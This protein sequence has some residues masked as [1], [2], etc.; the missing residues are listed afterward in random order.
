[1]SGKGSRSGGLMLLRILAS[2]AIVILHTLNVSEILYRDRIS[3]AADAVSMGIVYCLMW[4]VPVFVMVSGALLLDPAREMSIKK[5]LTRYVPRVLGAL[6][7]FV[8]IFRIFDCVM[9]KEEFSGAVLTDALYKL[10]SGSS[11]SHL[12]YLYMLIGLYLLLPAYRF[13]SEKCDEKTFL[14]LTVVCFI[15]LSIL[16]LTELFGFTSAFH[17]QLSAVYT[18]YFFL[19]YGLYSGKLKLNGGWA[20]CFIIA[21]TA[22]TIAGTYF[23]RGDNADAVK[24]IVSAYSSPAVVLQSAGI[25]ALLKDVKKENAGKALSFVDGCT[26]GI[27]L[28][29]MIFLRLFLRY[30]EIDPYEGGIGVFAAIAAG[31]FF[32]SMAITALLKL[33]PGIR[34]IL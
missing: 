7:L 24:G 8:F 13:I 25:F 3:A 28:I 21:G 33:I 10:V 22:L 5:I 4:A 12:W 31:S 30:M 17:L 14:Y 26:F 11:W 20:V 16:N 6:V 34:R 27:Y 32:A 23:I 18:L 19:G 29:H 2:F 9:N 15:F 1:M